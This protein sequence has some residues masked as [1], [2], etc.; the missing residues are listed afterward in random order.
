MK[1]NGK[2]PG[3]ILCDDLEEDEQ[4]ENK[5]RREKFQRWFYRALLPCL[6]KGGKVRMHGTILHEEALLARIIR[7]KAWKTLLFKAHRAF[8]D[9]SEI[10]WPEQ[11]PESR[12]RESATLPC[13]TGVSRI[14]GA[15]RSFDHASARSI[16]GCTISC[17]DGSMS[18]KYPV[19]FPRASVFPSWD[20]TI[21][22]VPVA[23][24]SFTESIHS[25]A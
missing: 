15:R 19:M 14:I 4:V 12:L 25:T 9:F 8:D 24:G 16:V 10:L 3:L 20:A 18:M 7:G 21:R 17:D 6:R 22:A 11:F 5:D 23:V 13:K 1:W 2:R